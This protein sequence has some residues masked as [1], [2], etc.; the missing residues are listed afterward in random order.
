M[1]MYWRIILASFL[2]SIVGGQSALLCAYEMHQ[3]SVAPVH[4]KPA[5]TLVL[6]D[7]PEFQTK[8]AKL[9]GVFFAIAK[10]V[11]IACAAIVGAVIAV[12]AF[13]F[14]FPLIIG[15]PVMLL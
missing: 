9:R 7:G 12:L 14:V 4:K 15:Q 5:S 2:A 13:V 8:E 3:Q 6:D 1:V 11:G 10:W